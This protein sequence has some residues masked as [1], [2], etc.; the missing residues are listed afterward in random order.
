MLAKTKLD[1]QF[2]KFLEVIKMLYINIPFIK[3]LQQMP[4]YCKFLKNILSNKE[5]LRIMKS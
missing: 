2:G 1:E 5:N 3:A 4:T